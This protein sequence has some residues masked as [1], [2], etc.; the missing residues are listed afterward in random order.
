MAKQAINLALSD[1]EAKR[2]RGRFEGRSLLPT[3]Q[4]ELSGA[5]SWRLRNG[6]FCLFR[7]QRTNSPHLHVEGYETCLVL[8]GSGRYQHGG[9]DFPLRAG[10]LFL[11]DPGAVHEISSHDTGDLLLAFFV[12]FIERS[13]GGSL[14]GGSGREDAILERFL[15]GHAVLAP[16]CGDLAGYVELLSR[17]GAASGEGGAYGTDATWRGFAFECLDRLA[18]RKAPAENKSDALPPPLEKALEFI[19]SNSGRPITASD[20]AKAAGVSERQLRRIFKESLGSNP[21]ERIADAKV[22]RSRHLLSMSFSVAEVARAIGES[23]QAQFCRLFKRRTGMTPKE[24]QKR[25]APRRPG[26]QL[27]RPVED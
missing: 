1:I 26:D 15:E 21:H 16:S 18:L 7:E 17:E 22:Q 20:T 25:H 8:D 24:F 3:R 10:D 27:T 11:A 23:S 14:K 2:G 19:R 4:E 13:E 12:I 9:R 5:I 6:S